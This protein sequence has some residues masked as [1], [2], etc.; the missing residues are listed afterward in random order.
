MVIH[1]K[2]LRVKHSIDKLDVEIAPS[3]VF[4]RLC[5]TYRGPG[6]VTRLAEGVF[7]PE[8]PSGLAKLLPGPHATPPV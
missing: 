8:R 6:Q 3:R 5:P 1:F 4:R 2:K 7:R